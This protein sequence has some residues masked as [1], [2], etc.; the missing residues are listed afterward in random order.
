MPSKKCHDNRQSV[1]GCFPTAW[2]TPAFFESP[3]LT[4]HK[5]LNDFVP[6]LVLGSHREN[7]GRQSKNHKVGKTGV[8]IEAPWQCIAVEQT[9]TLTL[10]SGLKQ[11]IICFGSMSMNLSIT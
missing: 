3:S 7:E 10:T 5:R 4:F 9:D 11:G 8:Y 6:R 2:T 1:R